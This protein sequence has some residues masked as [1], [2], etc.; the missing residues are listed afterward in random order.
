[1]IIPIPQGLELPDVAEGETIDLTVTF[2][3]APEGLVVVAIDGVPL[4]DAAEPEEKAESEDED[5]VSA[6]NRQIPQ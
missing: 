1:M 3:L 6:V 4:P 2:A 5:F